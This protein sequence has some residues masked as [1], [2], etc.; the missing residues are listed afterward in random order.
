MQKKFGTVLDDKLLNE[1]KSFSRKEH[2][3]LSRLIKESLS[4]F[5]K[6]KKHPVSSF[7]TIEA[8]FGALKIA[9]QELK[10]I[11]KEDIGEIN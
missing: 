3:T 1:A 5:L 7:S 2:T 4:E 10:N 6:R 9:P 8:S 11:L